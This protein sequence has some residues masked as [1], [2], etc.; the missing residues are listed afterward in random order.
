[1][2]GLKILEAKISYL[3]SVAKPVYDNSSAQQ[4]D[5]KIKK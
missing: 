4:A 5:N 2:I 1:M 3:E